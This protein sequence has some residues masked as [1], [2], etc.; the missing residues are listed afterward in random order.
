MRY[1][2][3]ALLAA[4]VMIHSGGIAQ[5]QPY[6]GTPWP[7]PGKIEAEDYDTGGE[8]VAYHDTD[9]SNSGG[10]YRT[11]DGV[12][13]EVCSEGGYNVGWTEADEWIEYTIRA[14]ATGAYTLKVRTAAE[15]T[16]GGLFRVEIGG[17]DVTGTQTAPGT[18]GWQQYT[19]VTLPNVHVDEGTQVMR[20]VALSNG[21]NVNYLTFV[22][23]ID[24][25]YPTASISSPKDGD[26]FETGAPITIRAEASDTDG[27]IRNVEFFAN[28]GMIGEDATDPYE[29]VWTPDQTGKW[30]IHA[31]AT[32]DAGAS[33]ASDSVEIRVN[34]PELP[35]GPVFSKERGFYD[36]AFDL[37]VSWSQ[38]GS[39][40]RYTLDGSD[41]RTSP[42]TSERVS[43]AQIRV[44]PNSATGRARTPAVVVRAYALVNGA[45]VT[46]AGAHTYI[47]VP[48]VKTQTYPGGVWPQPGYV[49]GRI[50]DYYDMDSRVVN[51]P[52]YANSISD[53]LLDI[54]SLCINTDLANLFDPGIGIY[55]NPTQRGREWERP[56]SIELIDPKR[57]EKGFQIN[58]GL[59]IRG[60]YS[61][62]GQQPKQAFRF[63][64]RSDYGKAKLEYPLFGDEGVSSFDC[65]DLRTS[66]NYS[67][68]YMGSH[69]GIFIRDVFSRDCQRDISQPYTRSRA[70]H[71]YLD[72]M[73][74]GLYQTEERPE[75][76][77]AESYFGGDKDNY[78]V[79]KVAQENGYV[80]EPTD[81]SLSAYNALWDGCQ[82]GFTAN[83]DYFKVQGRNADGSVNWTNPVLVNPEN[84]I[85]YLLVIYYTGNFDSPVSA[86]MGNWQPN[87]IYGIYDR[88]GRT[89]FMFFIHDAEHSLVQPEYTELGGEWGYDRT[90]PFPGGDQKQYF[91]PQW[92]HQKLSENAEY[93]A[94]F[95]DRVYRH[96]FNHGALTRDACRARLAARRDEI[97]MAVIAESAR[98]GDSKVNPPRTKD[99]D[100]APAVAWV[101]DTFFAD[102]TQIVL[103]QLKSKNLYPS[104]DPPVFMSGGQ[105]IL[106]DA[107]SL[108]PGS[109]I[110][111]VNQNASKAG[112]IFYTLDGTDPR[113]IGGATG[114]SAVDAGDDLEIPVASNAVL[115]ARVKNGATW[116]AVHEL[117]LNTNQ[118]LGG[119][120]ITEIQYHPLGDIE[121]DATEF[122]FL[123]LK[124]IGSS[125]LPLAGARFV[126]GIDF[127]FPAG[128]IAAPGGFIVLASN[129]A[130]F[131]KRYGFAPFGEYNGQLDNGGERVALVNASGD[132]L[133]S[134]RYNDKPPWPE[135]PDS[136]GQSLVA[137]NANGIGD[138]NSSDYWASSSKVGGSPGADDLAS[139][140]ADEPAR[141]P[142]SFTLGQ[143]YPNPFNPVTEIRFSVPRVS[144]VS[145]EID[146]L[147]GR[148]VEI[149]TR[150]R[151]APGSYSVRW[152]AAGRPSGVYF[153]RLEAQGV[154]VTRKLTLLK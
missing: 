126:K 4:F 115:K 41:P 58:A 128:S 139:G 6:G 30:F 137:R 19:W 82:K 151:F 98:W 42:S 47:F 125:P 145:V 11:A 153:C 100:W 22:R 52:K 60:G 141:I 110:R 78:D 127:S 111:L 129:S 39:A 85:D 72:G 132:T 53:A 121:A 134:V 37:T 20:F 97:D 17:R 8:G 144:T 80:M 138:P 124:N 95:G 104:I 118:D 114:S 112:A 133:I 75:A 31:V 86:F 105:N 23:E 32:D 136:T 49:N 70:Y 48:K 59:R 81:G 140:V 45:P 7:V 69:I 14:S 109:K 123:E 65:V 9:V 15:S 67:W 108:S 29:L 50:M 40:I 116:S 142:E 87:N 3:I 146:D 148:R 16:A 62:I 150:G 119:L 51:D 21:F 107:I 92:L 89:G 147:L 55:V 61:R 93:R 131:L 57:K 103:Q 79:V 35:D 135:E 120:R 12:D 46:D 76:S 13:I 83:S 36:S 149:L 63:F 96:F 154:R 113:A 74:W 5:Q 33:T 18:G 26:E 77:Y 10:Q 101:M 1:L 117:L 2:S 44:D 88:I 130:M 27:T 64:F 94:L 56:A 43:P 143:N 38:A 73:Y 34:P 28:G 106:D 122:E 84:L 91:N 71:L 68:S 66:Q 102:R 24:T 90:G 152:N 54:P 99:D 25:Q